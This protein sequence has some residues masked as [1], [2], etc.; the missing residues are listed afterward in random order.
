VTATYYAAGERFKQPELARTLKRI[1]ADPDDFYHGKLA[2]SW[3]L[4]SQK[5]GGLRHAR[6][7][8]ALH[9]ERAH[10][11]SLALPRLHGDQ[12]AA[13]KLWGRGAGLGAQHP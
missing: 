11:A 12:R 1:S 2:K 13:A 5:G 9:G 10:A 4:K 6:R 8:G 7:P 3:S